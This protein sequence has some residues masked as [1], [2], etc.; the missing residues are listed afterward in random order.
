MARVF[1]LGALLLAPVLLAGDV[2]WVGSAGGL[3]MALWLGVVPTAL[4]YILFARGLRT[5]PAGEVA[6][7]TLA[8]PVT[9][10]VL[11]AV[12]LA[13]R[14]GAAAAGGIA[15]ILGGLAVLAVPRRAARWRVPAPAEAH[16]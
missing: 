2:A 14:P 16:A 7:L 8:E 4:A 13:E 10:T 1:G 3:A 6:T 5:L 12:V 11:G 15:L 9:A